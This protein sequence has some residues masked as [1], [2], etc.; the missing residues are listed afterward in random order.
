MS[1][2]ILTREA[3]NDFI[4]R[5]GIE[6]GGILMSSATYKTLVAQ[7]NEE[8]KQF[9]GIPIFKSED[10]EANKIRFVI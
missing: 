2:T 8:M 6:P 7:R 10:I 1:A 5:W 3:L 4:K 9:R